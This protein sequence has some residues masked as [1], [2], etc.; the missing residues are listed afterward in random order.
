METACRRCYGPVLGMR[1]LPHSRFLTSAVC[2]CHD[3]IYTRPLYR[4]PRHNASVG[5]FAF[6]VGVFRGPVL[7]SVTRVCVGSPVDMRSR[8][9]PSIVEILAQIKRF[10]TRVKGSLPKSC[11]SRHRTVT[12]MPRRPPQ[13][14]SPIASTGRVRDVPSR[15]DAAVASDFRRRG[16]GREGF[17]LHN[18]AQPSPIN[19]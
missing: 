14:V 17:V 16:R 13:G 12:K 18:K 1:V 8:R 7:A 2:R 9:F 19:V 5:A 11:H 6:R 10:L 4:E 15:Q 3:L